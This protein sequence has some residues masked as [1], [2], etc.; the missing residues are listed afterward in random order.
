MQSIHVD[1]REKYLNM[2]LIYVNMK[3]IYVDTLYRNDM[4][5][6][7][8]QQDAHKVILILHVNIT[9]LHINIKSYMLT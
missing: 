2:Q 8:F 9:K 4:T 3:L 6:N 5:C 7:L 1:I